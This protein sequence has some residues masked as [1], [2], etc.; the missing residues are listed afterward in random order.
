VSTFTP[1]FE[2]CFFFV[3]RHQQLTRQRPSLDAYFPFWGEY[4]AAYVSTPTSQALTPVTPAA[5]TTTTPISR[6]V[7][8]LL[9]GVICRLRV[10]VHPSYRGVFF[11]FVIRHRQPT[12]RRRP[13]L[14]AY[15]PLSGGVICRLRVYVHPSFR[16]VFFLCNQ[17]PAAYSTTTP[18]SR[19]ILP[20]LGGV[21]C[22]LR[23]YVH[24]SFRGVSFYL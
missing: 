6:R 11:L 13:S 24:P 16:G 21:F 22:S 2:G 4:F 10:N 12:V 23:V 15:F 7:L 3:I 14:D 18:I 20:L 17:A 1:P 19:R 9:G 8:P 5:Y